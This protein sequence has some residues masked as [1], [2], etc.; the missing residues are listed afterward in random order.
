MSRH[1]FKSSAG[2]FLPPFFAD[3]S[4]PYGSAELDVHKEFSKIMLSGLAL[5]DNQ[6]EEYCEAL[7]RSIYRKPHPDLDIQLSSMSQRRRRLL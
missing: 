7:V 6:P 2:I 4:V 5:C 3:S 1:T